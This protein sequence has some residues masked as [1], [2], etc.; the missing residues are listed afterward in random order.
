MRGATS[1]VV[2]KGGF[3]TGQRC[4]GR[5]EVG[6][7]LSRIDGGQHLTTVTVSPTVT[8]TD[9]SVPLVAKFSSAVDTADVLPDA[10][11]EDCT[12][13]RVTVTVRATPVLA[14]DDDP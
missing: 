8:L 5:L 14:D 1:L 12:V 13:P 2:S 7:G 6:P 4:L 10:D 11:T 3:G 9:V